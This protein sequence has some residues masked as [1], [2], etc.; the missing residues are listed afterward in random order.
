MP[1]MLQ[2]N[3]TVPWG[4]EGQDFIPYHCTVQFQKIRF[5]SSYFCF[6]GSFSHQFLCQ[7]SFLLPY[8]NKDQVGK[9][10]KNS[11]KEHFG[12]N[13]NSNNNPQ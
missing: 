2:Q 13:C 9:K 7:K 4:S 12:N 5:T 6:P 11:T 8:R 1:E 10:K 3:G